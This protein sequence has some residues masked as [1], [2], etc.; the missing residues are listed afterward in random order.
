MTRFDMGPAPPEQ[1][2]VL[3][4]FL[5]ILDRQS[6]LGAEGSHIEP[7]HSVACL[8]SRDGLRTSGDVGD[9]DRPVYALRPGAEGKTSVGDDSAK[10][11]QTV[12]F[13]PQAGPYNT[14]PIVYGDYYYTLLDRGFMTCHD[15]RSG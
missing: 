13:Q 6:A 3:D 7:D 1:L 11:P 9:S 12:W 14:S 8:R 4:S 2:L 15:V 5:R 10:H